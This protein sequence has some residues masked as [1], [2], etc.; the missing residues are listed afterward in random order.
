[1]REGKS[2]TLHLFA[3]FML[4]AVER[5]AQPYENKLVIFTNPGNPSM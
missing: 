4:Q 2:P 1:L 5:Q 3:M